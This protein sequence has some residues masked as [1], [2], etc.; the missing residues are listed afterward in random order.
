[1][2]AAQIGPHPTAEQTS[3]ISSRCIH[4][5]STKRPHVPEPRSLAPPQEQDP[6]APLVRL[7]GWPSLP[8]RRQD[9]P[10]DGVGVGPGAA[11]SRFA[12]PEER[13]DLSGVADAGAAGHG[14]AGPSLA[15]G[16][17]R[18]GSGGC[19]AAR[20]QALACEPRG[21]ERRADAGGLAASRTFQSA[22]GPPI[23]SSWRPRH[24]TGRR[25][26]RAGDQ[27]DHRDLKMP[28]DE[29]RP[30]ASKSPGNVWRRI[31]SRRRRRALPT[32]SEPT[33]STGPNRVRTHRPDGRHSRNVQLAHRYLPFPAPSRT[34]HPP[35]GVP[36]APLSRHSHSSTV[37]SVSSRS[38]IKLVRYSTHAPCPYRCK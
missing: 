12:R 38:R 16:P 11:G 4:D 10:L 34:P 6:D 3:D 21:D 27:Q 1:M 23:F 32:A 8:A 14:V 35:Q 37:N 25:A 2:L 17:R 15:H 33:F 19:P 5:R 9:R 18:S 13:V 29:Q 20:P 22:H 30:F 26:G 28:M 7:P 24:R 31:R 36:M